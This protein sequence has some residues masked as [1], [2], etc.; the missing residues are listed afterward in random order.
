M[1]NKDNIKM[2]LAVF[3]VGTVFGWYLPGLV[4]YTSLTKNVDQTHNTSD[5]KATHDARVTMQKEM[6]EMVE[7]VKNTEGEDRDKAFI[8]QMIMHHQA[9]ITMSQSVLQTTERTEIKELAKK[10]IEAQTSEIKTMVDWRKEW[11]Q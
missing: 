6:K 3:F 8:D 10:I 4:H 11:F 1:I 7:T 2:V 9:A 5:L